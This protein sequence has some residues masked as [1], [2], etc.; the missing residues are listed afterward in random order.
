MPE[1]VQARVPEPRDEKVNI[2]MVPARTVERQDFGACAVDVVGGDRLTAGERAS[3]G[4]EFN[5]NIGG[6]GSV[7]PLPGVSRLTE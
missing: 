6:A 2:A 7:Q 3:A 5:S 1:S 4:F